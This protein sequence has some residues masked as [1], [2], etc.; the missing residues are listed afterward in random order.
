MTG[1]L[2]WEQGV[3]S[4]PYVKRIKVYSDQTGCFSQSFDNL[5]V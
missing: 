1:G 3:K 5:G 4:A 2:A